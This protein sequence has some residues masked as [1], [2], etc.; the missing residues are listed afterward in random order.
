MRSCRD[1]VL[2]G[3]AIKMSSWNFITHFKFSVI[4][5]VRQVRADTVEFQDSTYQR[6]KGWHGV[7][8]SHLMAKRKTT[9]ARNKETF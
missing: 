4:L 2:F 9:P 5:G 3:F 8:L 7:R 6:K 1:L